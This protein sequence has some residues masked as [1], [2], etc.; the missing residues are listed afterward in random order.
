MTTPHPPASVACYLVIAQKACCDSR[1]MEEQRT[2]D[3][4]VG[5]AGS[6]EGGEA[7][8]G[9]RERGREEERGGN[10]E[11]DDPV[12]HAGSREMERAAQAEWE[13]EREGEKD[14]QRWERSGEKERDDLLGN[15]GSQREGEREREKQRRKRRGEQM[16][17]TE[18]AQ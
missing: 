11:R 18:I 6:R 1:K 15:A 17:G 12:G 4:L 16:I 3:D 13:R 9:E 14:R 10:I 5:H 8:E 2:R 7:A